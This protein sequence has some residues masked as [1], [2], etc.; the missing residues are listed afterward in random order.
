MSTNL[1]RTIPLLATLLVATPSEPAFAEPAAPAAVATPAAD[2]KPEDAGLDEK[3]G[4]Q[5]KLDV[6][7]HDEDGNLVELR[8]LVDRPTILTLNYFR[9]GGICSPQLN[10]LAKAISHSNAVPGNDYRVI[11][12]SFDDR[13]TPEIARQ[14]RSNYL[15]IVKRPMAPADWRFLT[16][17]A[18]ST[19][20]LADSVGFHFKKVN[21]D[22]V[23]PG[24]LM[25]L[26]P[27]GK[28][29]RYMYGTSYLPAD[30]E[31]AVAEARRGEVQP[32]INKWLKYCYSYDPEGRTYTLAT[33]RIAGT[34]VLG[35]AVA[36]AA[37]M[38]FRGRQKRG[39]PAKRES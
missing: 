39:E 21:D 3:L 18:Q 19:R 30:I 35:A 1:Y 33:T 24:A 4:K 34:V 16:G 26:S 17:D 32:T 2:L 14:K 29:T 5:A 22:F 25:L 8:S 27:E 20:A 7:L 9:C 15:G 6:K 37:A 10:G 36:F 38:F 13:D 23:H 28:I 31:M 12:V 11:T